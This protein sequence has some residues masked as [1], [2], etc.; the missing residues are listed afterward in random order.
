MKIDATRTCREMFSIMCFSC[1]IYF[2][3][4]QRL[5]KLP[6]WGSIAIDSSGTATAEW[7]A[8]C[9]P[10]WLVWS[11]WFYSAYMLC[12]VL[13]QIRNREDAAYKSHSRVC[14]CVWESENKRENILLPEPGC[15]C[16]YL[17]CTWISH[18]FVLYP[19]SFFLPEGL[20]NLKCFQGLCFSHLHMTTDIHWPQVSNLQLQTCI[21]THLF[22]TAQALQCHPG[23]QVGSWVRAFVLIRYLVKKIRVIRWQFGS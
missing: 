18:Q 14:V 8:G 13:N 9:S 7:M 11:H 22:N 23:V 1:K 21:Q 15:M 6:C 12:G 5:G 2:Y 20:W 19:S 16:L 10:C 4:P 17:L 3:F